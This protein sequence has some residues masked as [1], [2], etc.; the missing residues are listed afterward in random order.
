MTPNGCPVPPWIKGISAKH[1][2]AVCNPKVVR[3]GAT[4]MILGDYG[5][6]PVVAKG[7][8][9]RM[10][11]GKR[12]WHRPCECSQSITYRNFTILF[13]VAC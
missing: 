2:K 12:V 4:A 7:N 8:S 10:A 9:P 1:I 5:L 13:P 6:G 11:K 3:K